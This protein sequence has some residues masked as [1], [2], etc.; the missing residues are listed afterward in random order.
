MLHK[1]SSP[2]QGSQWWELNPSPCPSFNSFSLSTAIS[3]LPELS[4]NQFLSS[5]GSLSCWITC[6]GWGVGDLA[7]CHDGKKSCKIKEWALYGLYN[8]WELCGYDASL[9]PRKALLF[10]FL[11]KQIYHIVYLQFECNLWI[12]NIYPGCGVFSTSAH[13]LWWA[14]HGVCFFPSIY[15]FASLSF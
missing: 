15:C 1:C 2:R 4:L 11:S 7:L 8:C 13:S 9:L 6:L 14:S 3:I 10:F 12:K 5:W